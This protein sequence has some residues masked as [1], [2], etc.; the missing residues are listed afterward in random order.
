M[1]KNENTAVPMACNSGAFT[2]EQHVRYQSLVAALHMRVESVEELPE[3]YAFQFPSE[4][5]ICQEVMEFTTLERLCCPF[6][7]FRLELA[8]GQGPLTLVLTGPS[9]V[10]EIIA[11]FLWR[12]PK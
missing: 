7:V 5:A 9:G 12:T 8:P 4:A 3:G 2:A 1:N 11:K 10:K 6:L